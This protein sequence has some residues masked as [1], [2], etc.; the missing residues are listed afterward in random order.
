MI[1]S[2]QEGSLVELND[3]SSTNAGAPGFFLLE[4]EFFSIGIP[5]FDNPLDCGL[6]SDT[7][8]E[9]DIAL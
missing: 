4:A 7:I 2:R 5:G 8:P 1:L 6:V 9:F 3:F